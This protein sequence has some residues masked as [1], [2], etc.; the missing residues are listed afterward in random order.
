MVPSCITHLCSSYLKRCPYNYQPFEHPHIYTPNSH[1]YKGISAQI[2]AAWSLANFRAKCLNDVAKQ[3]MVCQSIQGLPVKNGSWSS[4]H[5]V[6][7]SILLWLF[8][9]LR[10][11]LILR[12]HASGIGVISWSLYRHCYFHHLNAW[13]H[14]WIWLIPT[15]TWVMTTKP[16]T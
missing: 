15:Q 12:P 9:A 1:K 6:L 8:C 3:L 16:S 5:N 7:A 2:T 4:W 14:K 11:N 13:V 10:Y